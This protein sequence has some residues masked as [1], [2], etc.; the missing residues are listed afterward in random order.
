MH[1]QPVSVENGAR[2]DLVAIERELRLESPYEQNGHT[3]R[4]FIRTKDLR[5]VLVVM[6]ANARMA[7]H[8]AN[9]TVSI[10]VL[11]GQLRLSLPSRV[12]DLQSGQ[13][14]V[15]EAGL[16]HDVEAARDSAFLLTLGWTSEA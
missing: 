4:T 15:L 11:S 10:H 7:E 5:V 3:A 12:E 2:F 16:R 13:L 9:E 6:R 8:K 14:L 1:K